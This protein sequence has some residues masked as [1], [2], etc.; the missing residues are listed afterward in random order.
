MFGKLGQMASLFSNLPKL[1]EEM[2]KFQQNLGQ[3]TAEGEAG[4]GAVKVMVN[5]K[6]EVLACRLVQSPLTDGDRE[7]LEELI[8]AATN[9]AMQKVRQ[10]TAEAYAKMFVDLGLPANLGGMGLPGMM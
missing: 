8:K 7:M 4:A 2:K 1:Q 6:M 9:Q 5:G 3:L 10:Q